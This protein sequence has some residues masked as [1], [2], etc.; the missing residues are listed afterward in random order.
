MLWQLWHWSGTRG[1]WLGLWRGVVGLVARVAVGGRPLVAP[2]LVAAGAVHLAVGAVEGEA[3]QVV[4]EGRRPP[5][6]DRVAALAGRREARRPRGRGS[7]SWRSPA[8]GTTR[9]PGTGRRSLPPVWQRAQARRAWPPARGKLAGC[10]K[11]AP[12]PGRT[13]SPGGSPRSAGRSRPRRGW[14]PSSGGRSRGGSCRT[15]PGWWRTARAAGSRG[16]RRSRAGRGPPGAGSGSGC[17]PGTSRA[18]SSRW[19]GCGTTRSGSPARP[20]G[21]P[22]GS[23]RTRCPPGGRRGSGGTAGRTPAWC[24]AFSAKPG[25]VVPEGRR[26]VDRHPPLGVVALAAVEGEVSVGLVARVLPAEEEGGREQER[27]RRRGSR[28]LMSVLRWRADRPGPWHPEQVVGS[29][30]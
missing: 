1:R 16:R 18:G 9:S 2:A 14:G 23:P 3:G 20:G 26:L 11:R 4:V 19:P 24:E 22:G 30:R 21:R 25:R 28:R 8:G 7:W 6:L 12:S 17:G 29:G 15:R 5:G 13:P 27:G 10:E